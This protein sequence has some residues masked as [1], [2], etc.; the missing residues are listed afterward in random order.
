MSVFLRSF[1]AVSL[2]IIGAWAPN[3]RPLS[4]STFNPLDLYRLHISIVG[5]PHHYFGE[6]GAC[7]PQ[8]CATET[9]NPG[10]GITHP[11]IYHYEVT[12]NVPTRYN[13]EGYYDVI[14]YATVEDARKANLRARQNSSLDGTT[15]APLLPIA[16]PVA[17]TEWLRGHPIGSG[18]KGQCAA[19]SGA[20]AKEAVIDAY[21][22]NYASVKGGQSYPC[23][24]EYHWATRV[25][26]ALYNKVTAM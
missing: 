8:P 10:A 26:K 24:A 12:P 1:A 14:L 9:Y 7:D 23:S 11:T 22:I 3:T 5:K 16:G 21:V 2:A 19:M 20:R 25:L 15:P 17:S 4:A 18:V 13:V 6:G